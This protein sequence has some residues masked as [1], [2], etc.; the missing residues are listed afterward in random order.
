MQEISEADAISEGIELCN[1]NDK[2]IYGIRTGQ[3]VYEHIGSP[4][5][6]Y[7]SLWSKINGQKSWDENSFV[8][9][10]KFQII[11]KPLNFT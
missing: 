9:V 3:P 7:K 2:G 6:S 4:I 10:L 5:E 8:W 11:D 1:G